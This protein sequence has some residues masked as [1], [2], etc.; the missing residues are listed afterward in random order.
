M[1]IAGTILIICTFFIHTELTAQNQKIGF[2]D[3]DMIIEQMPEY[4]GVEQRLNLLSESW[5]DELRDMDREI[6]RLKDEFE[7]RELLYTDEIREQRL[8]EIEE[9]VNNRDRFLEEKFGPDGEY[10]QR[11]RELLEPVQRQVFDAVNRVAERDGFDFIFDRSQDVRFL[12]ARSEWNIT[13]EV[14]L[15]LGLQIEALTN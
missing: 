10:F 9:Q 13:E 11:Q 7:A 15:E 3:S 2:I 12:F 8:S 4:A 14:M 1:R 5:R 6:E